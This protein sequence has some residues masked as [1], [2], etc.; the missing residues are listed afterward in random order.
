MNA[1]LRSEPGAQ[2]KAAVQRRAWSVF[3]MPVDAVTLKEAEARVRSAVA[4]RERLS[5]VTP[6]LNWLV[7]ALREPEA[8]QQIREAD[9]SL[10]DGAPIVWLA[11]RLG[12]PLTERVAGS[13]LFD[14][15]RAKKAGEQPIRVFFFG[16]REGAAEIAA[17]NLNA[18]EGGLIAC[19]HLNPGYGDVPSMSAP[20]MIET[21]NRARPDFVL[22]SLGAAKGQAWISANQALLEAPVIAHL[23]AVVDFVA[24]TVPRAPT[25]MAKS[26]LE[27][28]WR[29]W[30]EPSLWRRYFSDG[31]ALLRLVPGRLWPLQ[32]DLRHQKSGGAL[33]VEVEATPQKLTL[34]L[35]GDATA[36]HLSPLHAALERAVTKTAPVEIDVAALGEIDGAGLGLIALAAGYTDLTLSGANAVHADIFE[37]SGL[38]P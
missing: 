17:A 36:D 34:R 24:D 32:R 15:L 38:A 37:L 4:T 33:E 35:T 20:V 30:A 9:L 13:D 10:A 22:V 28:L 11:R 26:G 1:A 27:W 5:F 7:R 25:W 19:G 14:R 18:E 6:N 29:I 21:I 23:G 3:G 12:A 2:P 16:G 8:M 31:L